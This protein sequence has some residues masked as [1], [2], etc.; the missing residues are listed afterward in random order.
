MNSI[1]ITKILSS[2]RKTAS[3]ITNSKNGEITIMD[4]VSCVVRICLLN[5]MPD[6][7]KISFG[8]NRINFQ[9]PWLLQ[10]AVRWVNG[11]GRMDL[12][13]LYHPLRKFREWS[14]SSFGEDADLDILKDR[15]SKGL[16]RLRSSYTNIDQ[17]ICHSLDLYNQMLLKGVDEMNS[18]KIEGMEYNLYSDIKTFWS[19]MEINI[20]CNMIREIE[21]T[22]QLFRINSYIKSIESILSIKDHMLNNLITKTLSGQS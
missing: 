22:I 4:P 12:H 13:N 5:Y 7:T 16:L 14:S 17:S 18:I 3:S 9:E 10:G 6:N 19:S 15:C 21:E 20:V 1:G 11:A 8:N 2:V